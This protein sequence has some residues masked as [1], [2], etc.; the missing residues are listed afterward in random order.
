MVVTFSPE[1]LGSMSAV[2]YFL[3]YGVIVGTEME[4]TQ[5]GALMSVA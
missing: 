1:N 2:R 3:Y 5:E 4:E